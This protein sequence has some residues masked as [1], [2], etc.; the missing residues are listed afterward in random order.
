MITRPAD[1]QLAVKKAQKLP[2]HRK[3]YPF[4]ATA[5]LLLV[6]MGVLAYFTA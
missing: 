4:W 2:E 6:F 1:P 5:L 3:T